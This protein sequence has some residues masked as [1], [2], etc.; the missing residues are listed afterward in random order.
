MAVRSKGSRFFRFDRTNWQPEGNLIQTGACR[1]RDCQ[2][3]ICFVCGRRR[4]TGFRP[5][6]RPGE[7]EDAVEEYAAVVVDQY[8]LAMEN[9]VLIWLPTKRCQAPR[10]I[11]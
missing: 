2:K 5:V 4:G 11:I 6:Q 8:G 9:D 3:R 7:G 10:F 1:Y